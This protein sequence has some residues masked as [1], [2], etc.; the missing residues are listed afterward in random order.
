M[1]RRKSQLL[2]EREQLETER[3]RWSSKLSYLEETVLA[4]AGKSLGM[5]TLEVRNKT[6]ELVLPD[7]FP[8]TNP[9]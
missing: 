3:A 2:R 9:S 7:L 6:R 1:Q 8:L 5:F 4:G